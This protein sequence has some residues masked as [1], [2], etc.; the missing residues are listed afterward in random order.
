MEAA[1]ELVDSA[2]AGNAVFAL[3]Q[4]GTIHGHHAVSVREPVDTS[5]VFQVASLSKWITA[6][7][8]MALVDD[9]KLDLDAPVGTYLTR[10]E[11]P[12]SEFD[13]AGVTAGAAQP[14]RGLTDDLVRRL[15][16][17][18]RVQSLE[19]SLTRTAFFRP[20]AS[21]MFG[22]ATIREASGGTQEAAMPASAL[23]RGAERG[24][25]RGVHAARVFRRSGCAVDISVAGERATFAT[26]MTSTPGRSHYRFSAV[27]AVRVYNFL[28]T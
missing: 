9:G 5:T 23:D 10:W 21:G 4:N 8:V 17:G 19:E 16:P 2:N 6:W 27:A 12:E 15:R 1:V 25:V 22:W 7:G 28:A 14:Y 24:T 20:G 18:T 11:L 3:I 26:C 13:N